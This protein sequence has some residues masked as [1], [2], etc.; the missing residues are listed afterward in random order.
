MSSESENFQA[1]TFVLIGEGW[2]SFHSWEKE[3]LFT[4]EYLVR[5]TLKLHILGLTFLNVGHFPLKFAHDIDQHSLLN[6]LYVL[7]GGPGKR[8]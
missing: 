7:G 1:Y 6:P 3:K 2:V 5:G 8:G 4:V